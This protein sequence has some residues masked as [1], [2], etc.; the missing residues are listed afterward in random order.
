MPVN[1]CGVNTLALPDKPGTPDN[2]DK[3]QLPSGV[4]NPAG[5]VQ[6]PPTGAG[7]AL[8]LFFGGPRREAAAG[9]IVDPSRFAYAAVAYA[10][11]DDLVTEQGEHPVSYEQRA[12]VAIPID[13][14]C[15]TAVAVR[16]VAGF[17]LAQLVEREAFVTQE[18]DR[19]G[20]FHEMAI[21]R[22]A[23]AGDGQAEQAGILPVGLIEE[24]V[25][26]KLTLRSVPS[27]IAFLN[28]GPRT[29]TDRRKVEVCSVRADDNSIFS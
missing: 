14:G 27:R 25:A 7:A 26:A 23:F 3:R 10:S 11:F 12:G 13:A 19:G 16:G 21:T 15:P 24:S 17:H 8:F 4:L 2:T 9:R 29:Q 1:R 5:H 20:A 22:T 6:E 18:E 28:L